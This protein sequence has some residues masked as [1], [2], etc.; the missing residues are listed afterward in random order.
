MGTNPQPSQQRG[1]AADP[2]HGKAR[3]DVIKGGSGAKPLQQIGFVVLVL[4]GVV[5][6]FVL[7][8]FLLSGESTTARYVAYGALVV[9]GL[10]VVIWFVRRRRSRQSLDQALRSRRTPD[11]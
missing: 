3:G 7:A 9:A 5:A 8:G 2:R 1:A 10:L 11:S 6:G 4:G